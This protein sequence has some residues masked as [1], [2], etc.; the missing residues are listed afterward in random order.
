[1]ATKN[2]YDVRGRR[3]LAEILP[4]FSTRTKKDLVDFSKTIR[5]TDRALTMLILNHFLFGF[6]HVRASW[7][8]V[9]PHLEPDEA[10]INKIRGGTDK[11]RLRHLRKIT[12]I[13]DERRLFTGHL[14]WSNAEWHLFFF[15]QRDREKTDNHWKFGPHVHFLNF[16]VRPNTS[17]QEIV[18]E[19]NTDRPKVKSAIH[20]RYKELSV[21]DLQAEAD[22]DQKLSAADVGNAAVTVKSPE[23]QRPL[24]RGCWRVCAV[25]T[26]PVS[27]EAF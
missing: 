20:I 19:L 26:L 7:E 15:D 21:D 6:E 3:E 13:F 27:S 24:L 4:I 18:D 1:M 9:P 22:E 5:V 16:L 12:R 25:L 11:E 14:F 10:T 2:G 17:V 23:P 8:W